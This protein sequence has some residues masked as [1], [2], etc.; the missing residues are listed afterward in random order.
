[1]DVR[2]TLREA[3]LARFSLTYKLNELEARKTFELSESIVASMYSFRAYFH[4]CLDTISTQVSHRRRPSIVARER[5][6][7]A[8]WYSLSQNVRSLLLGSNPAETK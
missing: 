3:E 4:Q 7:T 1:M 5:P 2:Q 6:S 8:A